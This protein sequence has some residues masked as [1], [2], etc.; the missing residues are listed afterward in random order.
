MG[1]VTFILEI[2]YWLFGGFVPSCQRPAANQP[3]YIAQSCYVGLLR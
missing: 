2:S 1:V 3:S